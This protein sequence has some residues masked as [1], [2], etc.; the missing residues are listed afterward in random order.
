MFGSKLPGLP[1]FVI[2]GIIAVPA[3]VQ[4]AFEPNASHLPSL[5]I[6]GRV[7]TM[8]TMILLFVVGGIVVSTRRFFVSVI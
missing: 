3:N 5:L 4:V 7:L 2:A 6:T 8:A 1:P